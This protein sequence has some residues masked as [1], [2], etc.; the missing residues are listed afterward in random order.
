MSVDAH[1][2]MA[3]NIA[4]DVFDAFNESSTITKTIDW[5]FVGDDGE[6]L[7]GEVQYTAKFVGGGYTVV[8]N[9]IK[10]IIDEMHPDNLKAKI[11]E[12]FAQDQLSDEKGILLEELQED[13]DNYLTKDKFMSLVAQKFRQTKDIDQALESIIEDEYNDWYERASGV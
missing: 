12:D 1:K 11:D 2:I 8:P 13:I 5:M 7:D 6:C 4:D 10:A 3:E 9:S